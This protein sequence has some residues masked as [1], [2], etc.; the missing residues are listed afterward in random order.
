MNTSSA[1]VWL[2]AGLAATAAA[3]F[4]LVVGCGGGSKKEGKLAGKVTYGGQP[5]GGGNIFLQSAGEHPQSFQSLIKP[6]G[7][8]EISGV[9]AG[10]YLV[11]VETESVK[12]MSGGMYDMKGMKPPPGAKV[13][14]MPQQSE[15]MPKYVAIP[16][17]YKD[18][19]TSGL[20]KITVQSGSK[21]AQN[22][23][24]PKG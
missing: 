8:Y 6:D 19:K 15:N 21:A 24:I 3:S 10:E 13:E 4:L 16:P 5:L 20:P 23:D 22:I 9:P 17:K 7:S 2:R 1:P 12:G 11:G 14:P 18:P